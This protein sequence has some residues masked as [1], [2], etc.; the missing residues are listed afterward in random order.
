MNWYIKTIF[1]QVST[2][3]GLESYLET[4]GA[5]SDIIQY[6]VTQDTNTSQYLTNELRKNPSL[7]IY[8]LQQI[9]LPQ[10]IDPYLPVEKRKAEMSSPIQQWVLVNYRKL[11]KG[12]VPPNN[13]MSLLNNMLGLEESI[14]Y[15]KFDGKINEILDWHNSVRPD[16]SSYS[17]EQ[18][19]QASDE[20]HKMMAGKGEGKNYEPTKQEL[21]TYGPE[22]SEPDWHGW[23]IQKIATENDLLTEGNKMDHCVGDYCNNMLNGSSLFYSLRDPQNKPYITIET[24]TSGELVKQI[25]GRFNETPDE[26]Y[27]DMIKEWVNKDKESPS[28]YKSDDLNW[29]MEGDLD[30]LIWKLNDIQQG[31]I[32]EESFSSYS[33]AE[34]YGLET[35]SNEFTEWVN[36]FNV[37]DLMSIVFEQ[38]EYEYNKI[39][40]ERDGNISFVNQLISTLKFLSDEEMNYIKT[41]KEILEEQLRDYPNLPRGMIADNEEDRYTQKSFSKYVL[42]ALINTPEG[43]MSFDFAQKNNNWYK[44]AQE[45][46]LIDSIDIKGKGKFYTDIG[47]DINYGEPNRL[48]GKDPNENYSN[49]NPNIMWI[50]NNGQIE[51][52]PETEMENFHGSPGIWGMS[53]NLGK[54]YTGRYS[55]SEKIITVMAPHVGINRFREIPRS[56]RYSLKQK[57]PEAEKIIRY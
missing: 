48:L 46:G 26:T 20:W 31:Y 8:Q 35:Q 21:I 34:Q 40:W 49:D 9:Q 18:A 2:Q 51:T 57:F 17:A 12:K 13:N 38:I 32:E 27:Q 23:T 10:K 44:K 3:S 52:K 53:S 7:N 28:Y 30:G 50:Y 16:I 54:L 43:Q 15:W 36:N 45:I 47:H 55:P 4:M 42:N 33:A 41:L 1:S 22:W 5:T 24:D 25:Q 19:I 56:I 11:R 14:N 6:I 39:D 37:I 29:E